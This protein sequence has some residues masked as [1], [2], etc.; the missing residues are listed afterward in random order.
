MKQAAKEAFENNMHHHDT[1]KTIAKAY[2][3]NR[4]CSVQEAVYH[5]LP[6]LKL[7]RIFPAVY[8]TN[9]NPPE[10]RVQVLLSEKELSELPDNSPNI[11][12]KCNID[13]YME[14][15]NATF[16]NGKCS[17][18]DNFCYAEFFNILHT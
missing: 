18:L 12:K 13:H 11:S 14:R 7:R 5:I 9:I 6:E 3:S 8:F 15:P 10:E 4:E 2:L 1:M 16:C 17:I